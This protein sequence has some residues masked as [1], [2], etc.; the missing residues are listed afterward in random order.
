MPRLKKEKLIKNPNANCILKFH[1]I[2]ELQELNNT[3][4]QKL[5]LRSFNTS[6]NSLS[7]SDALFCLEQIRRFYDVNEEINYS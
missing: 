5:L 2:L 4:L 3:D 7:T 6:V 1:L